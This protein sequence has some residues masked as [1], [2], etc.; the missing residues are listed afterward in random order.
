M[1]II[2]LSQSAKFWEHGVKRQN[3][4]WEDK[5]RAEI[6]RTKIALLPR[7]PP[8]AVE[9]FLAKKIPSLAERK[10][11]ETNKQQQS[12]LDTL[13]LGWSSP[14]AEWIRD[15][16]PE[17]VA[18]FD[19]FPSFKERDP[20]KLKRLPLFPTDDAAHAV[21]T[22]KVIQVVA[23]SINAR[24]YLHAGS[25]LGAVLHGQPIPW[26]D[27]VDLFVD[28]RKTPEIIEICQGEGVKV[29]PSGVRLRCVR[30]F[31][32][33]KVWL[34]PPGLL[35]MTGNGYEQYS[36]YVDLFSYEID[37]DEGKV[38]EIF[39]NSTKQPEQEY[40]VSDYF[41]TRPYYFAGT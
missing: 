15:M 27:D 2:Q 22:V 33:L 19:R 34:H 1:N 30:A 20:H 18:H 16:C 38:K 41:P 35:K 11:E 7:T 10:K 36:P 5:W 14:P 13:D 26:D 31:N 3:V 24:V 40:K 29:H 4:N 17:V 32:S 21:C 23:A 28:S 37:A 8:K 25:H 6:N 12:W 9:D 39:L